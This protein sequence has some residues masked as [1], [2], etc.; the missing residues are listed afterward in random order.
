VLAAVADRAAFGPEQPSPT[1]A[2]SVWRA[3]DDLRLSLDEDRTRW[4]RIRARVSLRS[5][6]GYSV[7]RFFRREPRS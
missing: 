2:D 1:E 7:S 3:V 6:G 4:E 5:L